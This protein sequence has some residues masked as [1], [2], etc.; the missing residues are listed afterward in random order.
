MEY[1]NNNNTNMTNFSNIELG[2]QDKQF[3][4]SKEKKFVKRP[5]NETDRQNRYC[6]IISD[7]NNFLDNIKN[8][9]EGQD[10]HIL[11]DGNNF[12]KYF[13][14]GPKEVVGGLNT[15]HNNSTILSSKFNGNSLKQVASKLFEKNSVSNNES[16]NLLNGLI[17]S[18]TSFNNNSSTSGGVVFAGSSQN[19]LRNNLF[20]KANDVKKTDDRNSKIMSF[21]DR[22]RNK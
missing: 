15:S 21:L 2:D 17:K 9:L 13:K 14:G 11:A 3:F 10:Q 5:Q 12:K 20:G 6:E 19:N 22:S 8:G 4:E 16:K 18:K 1:D 7:D